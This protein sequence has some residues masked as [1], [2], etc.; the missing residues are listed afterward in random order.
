MRAA[1]PAAALVFAAS[2]TPAGAQLPPAPPVAPPE[3]LATA[4]TPAPEGATAAAVQGRILDVESR[5]PVYAVEVWL[6]GANLR[7]MTARGGSFIFPN[8]PPGTYTLRATRLGYEILVQEALQ[9]E[10]G[11]TLD[12]A[13]QMKRRYI[14]LE[15]ITVTP[16]AYSF[17]KASG[18]THQTMSRQ[19]IESVPQIGEDVFRAVDR[20]PGLSSSDYAAHF[21]IRGGRHDETLILFDGL[22]LHEPYHLKDFNEGALS[23]IDVETI[24][25]IELMTGGFPAKYGNRRSG[26]F[27]IS[28]R[29]VEQDHARYGFGVSFMNA[30]ALARGPLWGK[31]G[32]WLVSA[33]SGYLD[34]VFGIIQQ[35]QLP[36]PRYHDLFT[37]F[38][39][40]LNPRYQLTVNFLYAGDRYKFDAPSTTGFLDSLRTRENARNHYG[41]TYAWT[42]LQSTLGA[43]TVVR[44]MLSASLL[45]RDRDGSESYVFNV[46]PLYTL[47]DANDH[48]VLSLKQDWTQGLA[49]SYILS[50]GFDLRRVQNSNFLTS[51]VG[52]D[53]ND[54]AQ[55]PNNV[56]PVR[57]HAST[58]KTGTTLGLYLS[59]RV[60][61]AKRLVLEIGGRYDGASYTGDHDFSPRTSAALDLG[62]GRT[63]R[64]GWGI[65]RQMQQIYE[66]AALNNDNRY[67]PAERSEQWTGGIEQQFGA[68]N[69]LRAE[70]YYKQG[71]NLRP[72][73]R[74]WKGG[75]DTF[76]ETNEDRILVHPRETTSK[77]LE[78]F[79]DRKLGKRWA[80][81]ASYAYSIADEVVERVQSV[82]TDWVVPFS[83][84]HPIPQD[85]R[86]AANLDFT[87][88][89]RQV[90][91][92]NGAFT[93]H[94]GWPATL[95]A[96]VPVLDED[97]EPDVAVRPVKLYDSQL[98]SY[99]RFDMRATRR[100]NSQR[101]DFRLFIELVNLT[102]HGNVFGYDY[103]RT[104]GPG[105]NIVLEREDETWFTILP[106][107]G[108]AWSSRF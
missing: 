29:T 40:D 107:I 75:V 90:W 92:L 9:V 37:K 16:G 13:L 73:Y 64:A 69:L 41:N 66:V 10:G 68:A 26:V 93:F 21:S 19:D 98:P 72:V 82:N 1:I 45:S 48:S 67:Y 50:Y 103:F 88:R 104:P 25:G 102:N 20:L 77:G 2:A 6:L 63:L 39:V 76:P 81:R 46:A 4:P 106:S 12:L 70:I 99:Y 87:M 91:S 56:Y 17:M 59:N 95:E 60:R 51:I 83:A 47:V 58:A 22:E 97:G 11:A 15:A 86:H 3:S 85:Q 5:T 108:F 36:S 84:E 44:T 101:G 38:Q 33:R 14:Q 80:T 23:I 8:V 89:M 34:L 57:T 74:N 53:P 7:T 94:S 65:Y 18:S 61:P 96:L 55:D 43:K 54:P 28:S 32:S 100:W 42:T 71:S 35:N 49:E 52:E 27:D 105:G 31:K 24:D 62:S 79:Y 78:I 30:R